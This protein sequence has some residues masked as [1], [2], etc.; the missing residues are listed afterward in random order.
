VHESLLFLPIYCCLDFPSTA[1]A[2]VGTRT[3]F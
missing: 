3:R 2:F 1:F